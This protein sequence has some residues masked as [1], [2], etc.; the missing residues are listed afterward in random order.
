MSE[1]PELGKFGSAPTCVAHRCHTSGGVDGG[2]D[3]VRQQAPQ[4]SN[5]AFLRVLRSLDARYSQVEGRE[6]L[7]EPV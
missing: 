6:E 7:F 4:R 3:T 5:D 2:T 1:A